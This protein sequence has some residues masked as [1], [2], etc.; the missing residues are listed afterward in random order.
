MNGIHIDLVQR[1]VIK[2]DKATFERVF[3]EAMRYL[4]SYLIVK[5]IFFKINQQHRDKIDFKDWYKW[6]EDP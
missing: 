6:N 1:V 2:W 5:H 3:D 4:K